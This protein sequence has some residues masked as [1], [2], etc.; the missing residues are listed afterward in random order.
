MRKYKI[1][2]NQT[3]FCMFHCSSYQK[4]IKTILLMSLF[5]FS[6]TVFA[7]KP[8]STP[9]T[10]KRKVKIGEA[11]ACCEPGTGCC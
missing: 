4:L 1:K 11:L 5:C 3:L 8:G 7:A 10:E 9:K 6:I 2:L